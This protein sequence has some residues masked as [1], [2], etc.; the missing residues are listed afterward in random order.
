MTKIY[1]VRGETSGAPESIIYGV[2]PTEELAKAR[3]LVLTSEFGDY[4]HD[5]VWFDIVNVGPNG[6]DCALYNR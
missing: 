2:Y 5:F 3:V 6:A 1:I 4:G